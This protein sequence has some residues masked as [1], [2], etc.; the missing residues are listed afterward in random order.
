MVREGICPACG[1]IIEDDSATIRF[2]T[3]KGFWV[4]LCSAACLERCMACAGQ[5]TEAVEYLP[6]LA[7]VTP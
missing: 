2:I 4:E 5:K 6:D 1:S 3:K 7:L